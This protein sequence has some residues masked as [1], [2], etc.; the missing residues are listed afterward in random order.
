M[1]RMSCIF[2]AMLIGIDV[3]T[4]PRV[5]ASLCV[6]DVC[7]RFEPSDMIVEL[8]HA[9]SVDVVA[10]INVPVIGWGLDVIVIPIDG[11]PQSGP[12]TVGPDWFAA[13]SPDGDGL[14]G[15]AFPS[16]VSGQSVVLATLQ[17]IP[18]MEG[19][20]DLLADTTMGDLTEG[21]ALESGGFASM[22]FTPAAI[23]VVPEPATLALLVLSAA[24]LRRQRSTRA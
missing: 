15:L 24:L 9:F 20:Y 7:V 13:P 21:F 22:S 19:H 5:M 14:A 18:S 4:A 16:P 1:S 17:Y 23:T 8:G 10:D 3:T 12:P 11:M 2:F 6:E